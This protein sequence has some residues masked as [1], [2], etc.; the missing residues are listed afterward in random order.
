MMSQ[1]TRSKGWAC[2]LVVVGFVALGVSGLMMLF[3]IR[4]P[5][6]DVKLLHIV[7]GIV[8]IAAGLIHAVLNWGALAAHFRNRSAIIAGTAAALLAVS[9]LFIGGAQGTGPHRYGPGHEELGIGVGPD[10]GT[11]PGAFGRGHRN[12]GSGGPFGHGRWGA[13]DNED[14][15]SIQ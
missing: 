13:F 14:A 9:L 6:V 11:G 10:L 15:G 5:L 1:K 3:H 7:M 4:L 2:A 8:F 12:G